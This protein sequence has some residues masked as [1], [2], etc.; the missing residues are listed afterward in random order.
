MVRLALRRLG[1]CEPLGSSVVSCRDLFVSCLHSLMLVILLLLLL[2]WRLV[3]KAY[4]FSLD[5]LPSKVLVSTAVVIL[6]G[7]N[8]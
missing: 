3:Q 8:I 5:W 7:K 4:R 2:T 6:V 1:A